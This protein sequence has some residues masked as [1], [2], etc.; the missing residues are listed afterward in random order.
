LGSEIASGSSS[1]EGAKG[2]TSLDSALGIGG[3]PLRDEGHDV[4]VGMY[5]QRKVY[6][7]SQ[8][9]WS[10]LLAETIETVE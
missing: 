8:I 4:D 5:D 9:D 6:G 7:S 3:R 10:R 1:R 2:L